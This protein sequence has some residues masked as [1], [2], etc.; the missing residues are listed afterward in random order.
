G[1]ND[2][3]YGNGGNDTIYGEA[4]NDTLIGQG[5]A[6]YID[7]GDGIDT[8]AFSAST[9]GLIV[10]LQQGMGFG[11]EA[12]G[13]IYVNIE[14]VQ[15]SNNS[16]VLIGN[17]G[18]NVLTGLAGNDIL[19]G[20]AGADTLDG[21]D[22]IDTARYDSS[23]A[24]V[25]INLLQTAVQAGGDAAGDILISIENLIGS[26]FDDQLAGG[27]GA[28]VL[29][30]GGGNDAL[31][32]GA[33][34]DTLDGGDGID[35]AR[36]DNSSAGISINLFLTT[37][38]TG[39]DAVGDTLTS[40]ENVVGS[41]YQ[42]LLAGNHAANVLYGGGG[43]DSIYGN[44]GNDTIYGEAGNDTLIGQGGADYIDG[45]DGID[46][47]GFD[48]SAVGVT[49][50]LLSGTGVGGE[51]EGDTYVNIENI[52]GS[53]HNDILI[54]NAGANVLSGLAGNDVLDGGA[55]ADTLDGGDGTDTVTYATAAAAVNVNLTTGVG[56]GAAAGDTYISIES[57]VGSSYNDTLIGNS[58]NNGF[59]GGLGADTIN[60]GGGFDWASYK[61]SAAGVTVNL[62]GGGAA[63]TVVTVE[64]GVSVTD[65]LTNIEGVIG[66]NFNDTM[67]G[68]ASA[69]SFRG[70]GGADALN[71]AGGND[72]YYIDANSQVTITDIV[73]TQTGTVTGGKIPTAIYTLSDAG[74]DT[75]IFGEGIALAD[76]LVGNLAVIADSLSIVKL[77][78]NAQS[79][80]VNFG[81]DYITQV[82]GWF[83]YNE[84]MAS[85][86]NPTTTFMRVE[87]FKFADGMTFSAGG[88]SVVAS[89]LTDASLTFTGTAADE[90]Y[91]ARGGD[92]IVNGNDGNDVLI[93]GS[94]NDTING[95]TGNDV[96]A[97][98]SGNDVLTGGTGF[99][100]YSFGRGD[101]F[102]TISQ[103]G[104]DASGGK[105]YFG[106]GI[107]ADQLWFRQVGQDLEVSVIG[108]TDKISVTGFF[109]AG[110]R[111][112]TEID[113]GGLRLN[114]ASTSTAVS[115]LVSAMAA[116]S[117]PA[118]GTIDLPTAIRNDAGVSTALA[119][120]AA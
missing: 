27:A 48:Y 55:G 102:D 115:Q 69:E 97:G 52:H 40:I 4:G 105:L 23:S 109:G 42:D 17:A 50:N 91:S 107:R 34:A 85:V 51:A 71:G 106:E 16:D 15:G 7:G 60:G 96:L 89:D 6:D 66:T 113:A 9:V 64:G 28:N 22:G 119:A 74:A 47:L 25:N 99:D 73:K 39:G 24:G 101:G 94:G 116:F 18:A 26:D 84:V 79:A 32:G 76:L 82:V 61:A 49:V 35:T 31:T 10:D 45:G 120:W 68:S 118:V 59:V 8:I 56:S 44:G 36:Y 46:T 83:A 37:A 75:I 95:G 3:I 80:N 114:T 65:T 110:A 100:L 13:D 88:I 90:W 63:S 86:S 19:E 43:N 93:G 38:Q 57:I 14:R 111:E 33:G 62:N 112:V 1:G 21:G 30:G 117:P 12:E 2:S 70:L 103:V 81:V 87:T 108:T 77:D 29:V 98:G 67:N 41:A 78:Q 53:N 58:G 5:G 11:G 20:G 92:D 72:T 104:A 54:G